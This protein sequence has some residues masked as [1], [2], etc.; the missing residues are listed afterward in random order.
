MFNGVKVRERQGEG[1]GKW[2][3]MR[4]ECRGKEEGGPMGGKVGK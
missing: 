4:G 3:K 2:E 1:G